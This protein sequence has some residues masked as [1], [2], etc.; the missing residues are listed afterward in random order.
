MQSERAWKGVSIFLTKTNTF[1]LDQ[2]QGTEELP[3][4]TKLSEYF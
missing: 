1:I 2:T 3:V 4:S